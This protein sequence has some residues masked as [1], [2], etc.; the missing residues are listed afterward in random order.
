MPT[1]RDAQR[2][3]KIYSYYRPQP[4]NEALGGGGGVTEE[5]IQGL[6]WKQSVRC[7]TIPGS[8]G[9][10]NVDGPIDSKS[11]DGYP[12]GGGWKD[13]DRVLLKDQTLPA[14]NGIYYY[15]AASNSLMRSLD[16]VTDTLT[17]AA[18]V[19]SE[20][21]DVNADCAFVLTTP[22]PIDVGTTSQTWVKF[23]GPGSSIFTNTTA[24]PYYAKTK[25][26]LSV[27]KSSPPRYVDE[28]GN[29]V[30]FYV[31]GTPG[32]TNS[33]IRGAASFGGDVVVTG[34]TTVK[35]DFFTTGSA[36]VVGDLNV[37]GSAVFSGGVTVENGFEI[38]G[39]SFQI[40]GSFGILGNSIFDGSVTSTLGFS[41]SLTKLADGSSYLIGGSNVSIT[42]GSN[43]SVTIGSAGGAS[44]I[45][46]VFFVPA[47]LDTTS[48]SSSNYVRVGIINFD[49]S[50]YKDTD[51]GITRTITFKAFMTIQSGGGMGL[52][53]SLKLYNLDNASDVVTLTSTA[54]P[55][56]LPSMARKYSS[57]LVAGVDI[58]TGLSTYEVLLK[59]AGGNTTDVVNCYLTQFEV[60]Y[61]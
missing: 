46:S 31:D 42:T 28:I 4:R 5:M 23:A 7:A 15:D 44:I 2:Y 41:G 8:S 47:S 24:V 49:P 17:A 52:E 3:R 16:S 33:S 13:G 10:V 55:S 36:S 35:G 39:D 50:T 6:D 21:G 30:F 26:A 27:D 57:P 53:A 32:S 1:V 43:G 12:F 60:T 59:R 34:S 38:T 56:D 61:T 19:F 22:D 11:I 37:T 54:T 18:A 25:Y 51:V 29:D 9:N 48:T 45:P 58:S 14:E 40:T 20:T